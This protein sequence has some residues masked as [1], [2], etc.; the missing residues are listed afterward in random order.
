MIN[1]TRQKQTVIRLR[2]SLIYQAWLETKQQGY[3][4]NVSKAIRDKI[5]KIKKTY[6]STESPQIEQEGII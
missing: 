3:I 2:R 4:G 5:R 1:P 6:S